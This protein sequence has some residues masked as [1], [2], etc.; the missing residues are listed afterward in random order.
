VR[1]LENKVRQAADPRARGDRAPR[2]APA[3][4]QRLRPRRGSFREAKNRF[5]RGYVV[6]LLR[7]EPGNVAAAAREA[8]KYR[9]EFY[10]LMKKHEIRPE[11]YR[12]G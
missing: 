7:E 6:R 9:A 4:R 8:G 10:D 12:S 1:E 2:D 3:R 5:E 11:D